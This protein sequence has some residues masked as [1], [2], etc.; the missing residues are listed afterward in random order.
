VK[1]LKEFIHS[2]DTLSHGHNRGALFSDFAEIAAAATHQVPY[3]AGRIPKDDAFARIERFYMDIIPR[4][5]RPEVEQLTTLYATATLGVVE[6]KADFLGA[7]YMELEIGNPR[8]GQFFT[9]PHVSR[10]MAEITFAGAAEHIKDKGY[11][12][13]DD[14]A[15]G[16][17]GMLIEAANAVH[18]QGFDPRST[19]VFQATDIDRTCFNMAYFQLSTLDLAGEVVHGNTLTLETWERRPTPQMRLLNAGFAPS[20]EAAPPPATAPR[21][22]TAPAPAASPARQ[23]EMDFG[24]KP[25]KTSAHRAQFQKRDDAQGHDQ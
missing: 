18:G 1:H 21:T 6:N 5:D 9:P 3:H 23:A 22:P 7:A 10:L 2:F 25:A 11:I 17:G 20:M 12:T 19:I 14:P 24:P 15:A 4:Y 8:S 13:V 16:A